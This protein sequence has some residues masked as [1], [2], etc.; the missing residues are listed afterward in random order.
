MLDTLNQ[1]GDRE[2][3]WRKMEPQ[4]R[5]IFSFGRVENG[6]VSFLFRHFLSLSLT[7]RRYSKQD[8]AG[9]YLGFQ[10]IDV[11]VPYGILTAVR[12]K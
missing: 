1:D 10:S 11:Q 6:A 2:R 8:D 3:D 7:N 12:S 4:S 9:I 5:L